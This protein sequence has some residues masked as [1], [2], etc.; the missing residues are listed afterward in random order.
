MAG[1]ST[2]FSESWYRVANLKASLIPTVTMRKQLF[3]GETWYVLSD[4]FNKQFFRLQPEA[5]YFVSRL[6][7][8]RTVE[9]VWTECLDRY[10]DAAPGQED[11]IQLLTQLYQA[12]LLHSEMPADSQKLFERYSK[13]SHARHGIYVATAISSLSNSVACWIWAATT[14]HQIQT[15]TSK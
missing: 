11:V 4:P 8:Q 15:K 10:P 2:T 9:E 1:A 7:P 12:N 3:R 14:D 5:H 13:R 6:H